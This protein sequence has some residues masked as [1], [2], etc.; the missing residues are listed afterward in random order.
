MQEKILQLKEE[1]NHLRQ[2]Q[3]VFMAH[4][5]RRRKEAEEANQAKSMFLANMSHEIRT[6][7][8]AILA[9]SDFILRDSADAVARENA[10]YIKNAS[11]SLL[12]IINDILD[13]SKIEAGKMELSHENFHIVDIINEVLTTVSFKLQDKSV[14]LLPEISH[15]L[16]TVLNGDANRIKQIMINILNNAAKFT[17]EG[18]IKLKVSHEVENIGN[19]RL[20]VSI[21]DTGIGVKPEDMEKLFISF[22]QVDTKKNRRIEGTGLGLAISKKLVESMGG[23]IDIKS[24]YGQGTTVNF[25]ICCPVVDNKPIGEFQQCAPA[26]GEGLFRHT[27]V[28][29]GAKILVVDDNLVNLQVA[30]GMMRYYKM[31]IVTVSNG[32]EA[33]E[34][35]LNEDFHMIFMDHMMPVM[36]GVEVTEMLR[37]DPKTQNSIIIALTANATVDADQIYRDFG[38]N[39]YL[40]KP[41]SPDKLDKLLK[42]YLPKHL[43]KS[44]D[45]HEI[46]QSD[47]LEEWI[48]S[49]QHVGDSSGNLG[50]VKPAETSYTGADELILRLAE[51][52]KD[53][54]CSEINELIAHTKERLQDLLDDFDLILLRKVMKEIEADSEL[55]L[56]REL[57]P[58]IFLAID[59]FEYDELAKLLD[60][61][62]E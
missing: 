56:N 62:W 24:V 60:E 18:T 36:D 37:N 39:D 47:S 42:K 1:N 6:P 54:K 14:E 16:P 34:L 45:E 43:I 44:P 57:L 12:T 23:Q 15:K 3:K 35:L 28:A 10:Q 32:E 13:F 25:Y 30:M 27:F 53:D 9:M 19:I 26:V 5:N 11:L 38:F 52:E 22:S 31:D 46:E 55:P 61:L 51:L 2:R 48:E 7:M 21:E 49:V 58:E 4:A 29:P 8:N 50:D 33:L 20:H 40:S 17:E 59:H 41:I